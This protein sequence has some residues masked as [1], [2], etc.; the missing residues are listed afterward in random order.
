MHTP[1]M[2]QIHILAN[3]QTLAILIAEDR[4]ASGFGLADDVGGAR[5]V[6]EAVVDAAAVPGVDALGASEGGV[7]Y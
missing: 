6:E 5:V 3:R 2:A 1:L 7:A 4:A